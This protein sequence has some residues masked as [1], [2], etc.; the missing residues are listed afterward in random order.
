MDVSSVNFVVPDFSGERGFND[1]RP[2]LVYQCAAKPAKPLSQEMEAVGVRGR[3]DGR[4]APAP[5]I[6]W[7]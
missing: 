4:L 5:Q 1:R 7:L 3:G 6:V 2:N